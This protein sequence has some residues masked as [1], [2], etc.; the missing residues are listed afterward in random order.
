MKSLGKILFKY[1]SYT[2]IPFL[3]VMI[4]FAAPNIESIIIGLVIAIIGESIRLWG[5]SYFGS[6][7]RATSQ[8]VEAS[9]I[10]Q[11]PFSYL[12]NPLYLGNIIIY[13]GLGIMSLSLFPYLQIFALIYFSFQYY[14][15]IFNEEE[16][17]YSKFPNAFTIYKSTVKRFLPQ[18]NEI[19]EEIKSKLTFNLK[20]GL[21]SDKRSLQALVIT[22]LI[23]LTIYFLDLKLWKLFV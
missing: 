12:R 23:I 4:V 11:G 2:P 5:V 8:F 18:K 9:L 3:F 15:I 14:C 13:F 16:Y 21:K 19:P 7:S 6:V 1:R 22:I 17:L 10:T 20:D